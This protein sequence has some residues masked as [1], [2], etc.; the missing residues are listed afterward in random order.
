M[1]KSTPPRASMWFSMLLVL[2]PVSVLFHLLCV[3]VVFG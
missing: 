2:V 3:Y 1:V